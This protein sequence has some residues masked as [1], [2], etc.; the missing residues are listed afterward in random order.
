MSP[1]PVQP[2]TLLRC[3]LEIVQPWRTVFLQQ[4]TWMRA[5][6]QALGGLLV[7]GRATLSRIL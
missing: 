2:V 6:R 1:D 5:T 7:L 3:W 4:R